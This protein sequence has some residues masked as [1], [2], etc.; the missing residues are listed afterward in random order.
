MILG[1]GYSSLSYIRQFPVDTL[2]ID[3][4]FINEVTTNADDAKLIQAIIAMAEA[5]KLLVIAEGVESIEQLQFLK[6]Q[7]CQFAQGY[8]I[9]PPL[10]LQQFEEF[11]QNRDGILSFPD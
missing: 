9:S 11:I 6:A 3:H 4:S 1:T 2:K 7:G 8:F 10:P 5:L